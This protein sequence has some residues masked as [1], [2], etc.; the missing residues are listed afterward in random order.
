MT[1]MATH[2]IPGGPMYGV[3]PDH[4]NGT[5]HKSQWTITPPDEVASFERSFKS[6]WLDG[7]AAWGLHLKDGVAD[8]LGVA[9]DHHTPV[10]VAKFVT[11]DDK[12][13][14][15]GYPAD[16]TRR[17]DRPVQTVLRIWLKDAVLPAAKIRKL[18]KGEP[19][20]L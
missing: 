1:Q 16:H 5:P 18:G 11:A 13:L 9:Q 8:Y 19:C 20:N 17:H 12:S 14:W 15:H 10:F 2:Q 7:M 4:R 6:N 3:H